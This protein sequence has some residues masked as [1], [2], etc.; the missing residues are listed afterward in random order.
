MTRTGDVSVD[1]RLGVARESMGTKGDTS[2][3]KVVGHKN[4]T[5]EAK[6]NAPAHKGNFA[7]FHAFKRMISCVG[8]KVS[9]IF[10]AVRIYLK[11]MASR[12]L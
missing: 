9:N 12:H 6:S 7:L 2:K 11:L 1:V 5:R 8:A 3:P 4:A 10:K